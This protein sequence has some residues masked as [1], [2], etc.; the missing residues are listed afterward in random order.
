MGFSLIPRAAADPPPLII[1]FLGVNNC[2]VVSISDADAESAKDVVSIDIERSCSRAL[3]RETS[4]EDDSDVVS[5]IGIISVDCGVDGAD[6]D[7]SLQVND[8]GASFKSDARCS[9]DLLIVA[10][11]PNL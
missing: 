5:E 11:L 8:S 2:P 10:A 4:L 3:R 6:L 9:A 7:I 1:S